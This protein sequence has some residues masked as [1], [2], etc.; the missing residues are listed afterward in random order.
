MVEI[1]QCRTEM[2]RVDAWGAI[3]VDFYIHR[4]LL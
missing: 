4:T 1:L 3:P 2:E